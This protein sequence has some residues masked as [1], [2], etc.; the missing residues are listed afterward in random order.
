[1][2]PPLAGAIFL[3][4]ALA[5]ALRHVFKWEVIIASWLVPM[6]V[7]ALALV[8]AAYL[9]YLGLRK[10]SRADCA[11]TA[12]ALIWTSGTDKL[13]SRADFAFCLLILL[14]TTPVHPA[15]DQPNKEDS[16]G[17]TFFLVAR[18]ELREP[19]FKE[20]VILRLPSSVGVGEGLVVGLILNKPARVA[21]SDIFPDDQALQNRSETVYFGGPV[22]PRAPGLVFRASKP[23][24]Q[25]A[26][27]FGDI[28]VSFDPDFIRELL[29]EPE[30]TPDLRLFVGRSQW[31]RAQLQHEM[32]MG[33]WY[34]VQAE[35]NLIFSPSSQYLWRKLFDR[36]EPAPVANVADDLQ[37]TAKK[38]NSE[39]SCK[40]IA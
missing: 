21:L 24:K 29:K 18:P 33:A 14:S 6:W 36:T 9:A 28:Y 27:L 40:T 15:Q 35:T 8:I 25:A 5:H 37:T 17:K 10:E 23:V 2:F 31:A 7:S 16:E 22:E 38:S 12:P 19:I 3:I 32:A 11:D 39:H 34:S 4:V 26:L 30:R 13:R 20:S 1:M